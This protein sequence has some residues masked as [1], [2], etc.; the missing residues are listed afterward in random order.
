MEP[1]ARFAIG[2]ACHG[3]LEPISQMAKQDNRARQ[4]K[5]AEEVAAAALIAGD[6]PS[7]VLQPGKQTLDP[8]AAAVSAQWPT[9]LR[10]VDAVAPVGRDQFDLTGGERPVERVAVIG[11]VANDALGIVGQ[12]ARVQRLFDELR[13]V[14]RGRG[15]GNGDRKTSAVC[16]GHDLGALPA[17][18]LADEAPFFL[19]LAKDPSMNVSLRSSPPRA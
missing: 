19:A 10:D 13:F 4:V 18:G 14:R 3:V 11:G 1:A 6:E 5:K 16:K 12:K 7:R 17:L 2:C 8:P 15:D 9:I